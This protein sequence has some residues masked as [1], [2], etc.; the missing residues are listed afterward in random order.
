MFWESECK[1]ILMAIYE[2]LETDQTITLPFSLCP[3]FRLQTGT[4]IN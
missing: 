1:A 4:A 2:H 3:Q